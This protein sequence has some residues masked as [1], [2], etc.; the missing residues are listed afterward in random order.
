MNIPEVSSDPDRANM[1]A[2]LSFCVT[3]Y[4][5]RLA[6]K[7]QKVTVPRVGFSTSV[8]D[9]TRLMPGGQHSAQILYQPDV[10]RR[11]CGLRG[12]ESV[13][14]GWEAGGKYKVGNESAKGNTFSGGG[15]QPHC[16]NGGTQG[17]QG[18]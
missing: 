10:L 6:A 8:A 15:V 7:L 11:M 1:P 5:D 13:V 3:V 18:C 9:Q 17:D 2:C 12:W 14:Y 16:G 4:V